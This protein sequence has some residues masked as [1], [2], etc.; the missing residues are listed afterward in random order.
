MEIAETY[1]IKYIDSGTTAFA[2]FLAIA[3]MCDSFDII[4]ELLQDFGNYVNLVSTSSLENRHAI[5][6]S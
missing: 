2:V 4:N 6:L 3:K 1:Y 5:P